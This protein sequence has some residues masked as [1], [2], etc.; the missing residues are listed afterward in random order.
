MRIPPHFGV[1]TPYI[2]VENA[3]SYVQ[4]LKDGLNG[5]ELGRN[6]RA[7]GKI[8]NCQIRFGSSTVMVSEASRSFPATKAAFYLYV[9]DADGAV[10]RALLHGGVNIMDVANMPYGDRQGGVQ[11]PAG[12]IWW[13]SQRL[14]NTPYF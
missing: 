14:V 6:H 5:I 12:N 11:D 10:E 9:E 2:V 7:D 8:A 3:D 1:V 4:F 13:I